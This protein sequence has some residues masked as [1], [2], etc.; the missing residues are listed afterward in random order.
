MIRLRDIA[1]EP[2]YTPEQLRRAAAG[3]LRLPPEKITAVHLARRSVDARKKPD[4]KM[5]CTVDVQVAVDEEKLLRR[6]PR[7][8]R[9]PL[10]RYCPPQSAPAVEKRPVVVGFGPAGMFAALILARAGLRPLV[11]ERGEDAVTRHEKVETF[12]R[13]GQLD[14]KTNVQFG[15]GGA[16]T[17]SDGKLNTGLHNIRIR[18]VLE[19]LVRFGAGADILTD[20]KP[21]IG[22]DVL[23]KVVCALRAEVEQLGG[24]ACFNTKLERLCVENGAVTGLVTTQGRIIETDR[25]ILAIG[26]SARDTFQTLLEQGVTMEAKPFAMGVRIEHSQKKIDIAQYGREN[27]ALPPADYKLVRHLADA[28]VYT[29]CMCPGGYV[30]AAASEPGGIVTNGMSLSRRDGEN[31]NAALLVSVNPADFPGDGPLAGMYWQRSIEQAAY[32]LTGSYRA[33]AQ[34]VGDF[35]AGRPSSRGGN[36]VPTY[37]PGVYWCDLRRVLPEK[38][39]TALSQALPQLDGALSGFADADAVLTAPETRSSSPVRIV[40]GENRQSGS[41]SGLFPAGEG[42]GYAGGIMSAAVDGIQCAEALI[43]SLAPQEQ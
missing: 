41:V 18:W 32:D 16:G 21:H 26:H 11:L 29:F 25:V 12:W 42:A 33:P 40:R 14:E 37:R 30:V 5:V 4:V 2:G 39:I 43:A 22:T 24:E 10:E 35:L 20:A 23:V 8:A 34:T 31:A 28:T 27:A 3:L 1:M 19:Q 38:I 13:T 36:V 7:A 15:E 17:F 6:C 9:T